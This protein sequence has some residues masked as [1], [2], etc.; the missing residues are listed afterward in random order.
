MKRF[1]MAKD[2]WKYVDGTAVRPEDA[3]AIVKFD[4]E[5]QKR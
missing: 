2:L 4:K 3:E 5:K 1:L